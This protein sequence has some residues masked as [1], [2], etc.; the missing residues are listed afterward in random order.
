[1]EDTPV[2]HL[3]AEDDDLLTLLAA[4]LAPPTG[5]FFLSWKL[6]LAQLRV[7]VDCVDCV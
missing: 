3:D 5:A 2:V 7:I 6:Q 4:F 1:M